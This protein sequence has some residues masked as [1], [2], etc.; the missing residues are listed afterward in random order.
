M[1]LTAAERGIESSGERKS[2]IGMVQRETQGTD[3]K[4]AG[5]TS[6]LCLEAGGKWSG[7]EQTGV[8]GRGENEGKVGI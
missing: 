5:G 1:G 7:W 2:L 3:C 4:G 6:S 8:W